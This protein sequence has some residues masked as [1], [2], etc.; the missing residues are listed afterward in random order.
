MN[1]EICEQLGAQYQSAVRGLQTANEQFRLAKPNSTEAAVIRRAVHGCLVELIAAESAKTSH[2]AWHMETL[3]A[4]PA[5]V[6]EVSE[7]KAG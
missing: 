1:C 5:T 4:P 6:S 7:A 2:Q 3:N